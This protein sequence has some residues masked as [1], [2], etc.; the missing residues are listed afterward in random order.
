M[1]K[2]TKIPKERAEHVMSLRLTDTDRKLVLHVADALGVSES[3]AAR[4]MLR[5]ADGGAAAANAAPVIEEL[6]A[7]LD[8]AV[9]AFGLL[10]RSLDRQGVLL[11]QIA[12][13]VNAGAVVDAEAGM[14]LRACQHEFFR[15]QW[16]LEKKPGQMMSLLGLSGLSEESGSWQ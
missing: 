13:K 8:D 12:R 6:R 2:E 5:R 16:A 15:A 11:N 10:S 14:A 3:K 4:L 1:T 9:R 7:D